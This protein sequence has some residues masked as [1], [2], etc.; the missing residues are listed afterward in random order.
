MIELSS[1]KEG[2]LERQKELWRLA[3][4]DGD[5]YIEAYYASRYRPEETLV[6]KEGGVVMSMLAG[7]PMALCSA[8]GG[9]FPGAYVYALATHPD[10]RGQGYGEFLLKYAD[11]RFQEEKKACALVVPAEP[12]LHGY[13]ARAGFREAF[14]HWEWEE[15]YTEGETPTGRIRAAEPAAY[16]EVRNRLL[17]G[18]CH[19]ACDEEAIR[20]QKVFSR[21][22]GGDIYLLDLPEGQGC[23]AAERTGTGGVI[24]KEL[25]VPDG[26]RSSAA[27]LLKKQLPAPG[28]RFRVPAG[29]TPSRAPR[30][31]P[32]VC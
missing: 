19:V 12:S 16:N 8:D 9:S 4:G 24:V 11:F 2:D 32:S 30:A 14:A 18:R 31:A 5:G 26:A 15:A 27:A 7:L 20:L 28:Y 6:L 17:R 1:P 10:G 21:L 23:A 25:L 3:F 13:F 29:Q 22:S